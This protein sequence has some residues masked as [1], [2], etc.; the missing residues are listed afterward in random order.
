M[1]RN[2]YE[3]AENGIDCLCEI[4]SNRTEYDGYKSH[5]QAGRD[6]ILK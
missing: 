3:Y 5:S 1:V 6:T 2:P 4:S